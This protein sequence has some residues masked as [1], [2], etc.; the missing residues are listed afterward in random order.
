[1]TQCLESLYLPVSPTHGDDRHDRRTPLGR[2]LDGAYRPGDRLFEGN[3]RYAKENKDP[4]VDPVFD[5]ESRSPVELRK[6]ETLVELGGRHRM[7]RLESHSNFEAPGN[8][9]RERKGPGAD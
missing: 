5:Q 8:L 3:V 6:I 2:I 4:Q 7:N 9:T 1:M